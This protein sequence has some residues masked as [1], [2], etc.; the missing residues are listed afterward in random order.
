MNSK[1]SAESVIAIDNISITGLLHTRIIKTG[2]ELGDNYSS[3]IVI[4]STSIIYLR[5]KDLFTCML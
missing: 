5:K 3:N 4:I 1:S 2:Y